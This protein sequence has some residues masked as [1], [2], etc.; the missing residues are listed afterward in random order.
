MGAARGRRRRGEAH[1]G[2]RRGVH[3]CRAGRRR[4]QAPGAAGVGPLARGRPSGGRR[5]RRIPAGEGI[6][7]AVRAETA[8]A[9]CPGAEIL[10]TAIYEGGRA[11]FGAIGERGKPSEQVAEEAVAALPGFR[12]SGAA[13][14]VQLGDQF[15]RVA[16]NASRSA[17]FSGPPMKG[18]TGGP[19][20]RHHQPGVGPYGEQPERGEILDK[21]SQF[22]FVTP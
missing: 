12:R 21:A 3:L 14:D 19:A 18:F 10:L 11:G 15:V 1:Q 16:G 7:A 8:A 6:D 9:A 17:D 13:A 20:S 4:A 22:H 5:A 2:D